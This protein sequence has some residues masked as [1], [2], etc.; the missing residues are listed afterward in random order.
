MLADIR[1][2]LRGFYRAPVFA[3]VA[4]VS[5]ALGIGANTA[6]FSLVN[7]VLLRT[8]PVRDPSRLVIFT[9]S[10][11]ERRTRNAISA[12]LYQQIRDSNTVLEGFV[13]MESWPMTLSGG[14]IAERVEGQL[15]SGNFFKTLGVNA[16]IGRVLT[17]EDDLRPG[18]QP[19]CVISYGF[20]LRR[21]GGD[22]N[23]IGRDVRINGHPFTVLGVTP[24]EFIGLNQGV[25]TD[26]S[27]PLMAAGMYQNVNWLQTFGRLKPS[28][29]IAQAQASLDVLYHRFET[30]QDFESTELRYGKLPDIKV[31]LQ[32]GGQGLSGLRSQYERPLLL[33][34]VVVALVLLIACANITNLL[35]ARASGRAKEI[36][37]RLA[38]GARLVRQL[39]AESILLA[40]SGAALG[41]T[42][43]YWMDHALVAL[44]PQRIGGALTVDVNADWR[45][46]LFTLGISIVVS[47][48]SG[49]APAIR[50]TRPEVG[51]GLKGEI[52]VRAP[53]RFSFTNALVV[54]QVGLSLVLLIGA[55]LFLRSLHNLKSIDPGFDPEHMVVLT[56]EPAYSGYSQAASQNFFATLVERARQMPGVVSASPSNISPLSGDFSI[57]GIGLPGQRLNERTSASTNWVGPDYFK[58]LG[59][60]LVAGR[61]FTE[62]DGLVNKVAIVNGK[63]AAHFWPDESPIGKHVIIGGRDNGDCE[64]IGVV[65]DVKSDSL[66]EG[67]LAAL[68]LPFRQ[69][70]RPRL[71]LHMRVT[72]ST[73]P[74]ISALTREIHTLDPNLPASNVTTMA[75]QL[76][77]TIGLDRLMATLTALFGL[78]GVVLAAVGLY[79]VMAFAVAARTH[80]IGIRMALGAGYARV[81]WQVMG[82][83]AALI[84]IGIALGV[85]GAL[86]ASRGV[87]SFLYGLSAT[88]PWTYALLTS[89]LA[90]IALSA[91]WI[92]ARR[93]ALVDPMVALRYE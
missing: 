29:S 73:T 56:I 87:Q 65:K 91:A 24:K 82:E 59:T 85:P 67:A 18:T 57:G 45:V 42:L 81:L 70:Q 40:I 49:I 23:V 14:G 61:V 76:D 3:L 26:I 30:R 52:G 28:V 38:L 47:V 25:Q 43:A 11:P 79:G 86:W 93:A 53:G 48:L 37:V 10:P 13:A 39:L 6:I 21:F 54:A 35:M 71:T 31:L 60:P 19:V 7:V 83:S 15:V 34:M 8:L 2:A 5:L 74:V 32:P 17:P 62:Q 51:P 20:W 33:L 50:S 92:P 89:A 90:G 75:A 12:K 55:G 64:V 78:L 72:G 84:G 44:A 77:R 66:R 27:V 36:A 41:M 80:E 88:D 69:N 22:P 68:Y 1:Y 16:L 63:L 9:L 58:T 46:L 4:V